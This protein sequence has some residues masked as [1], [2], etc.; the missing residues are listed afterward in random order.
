MLAQNTHL[1]AD[2]TAIKHPQLN[3]ARKILI[4]EDEALFARAVMMRLQKAGF[5]CEHA[6]ALQDGRAIAKQF[7]PDLV[8]LDMRLPDG[9]GLDVLPEFVANGITVIVMTAHGDVSDAVN[10]IKLGAN[11]YLKKPIDLEELLLI[12]QKNEKT[13][14][15]KTSL[16][17]SRQR[18]AHNTESVSLIGESPAI[19]SLHLQ[20]TR[21][22]QLG[23]MRDATPPTVLISGETGTGK[24]VAARLLHTSYANSDKPFVHVDCASLPAELIESELPRLKLKKL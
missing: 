15:L 11:D 2:K 16:D 18:N 1:G 13:V 14:E 21:I 20:I 7:L 17:Y 24:D 19:Q 9:N 4:V 23:G 10:A 6:E 8:L 3:Q 12:V 22:A 5:E